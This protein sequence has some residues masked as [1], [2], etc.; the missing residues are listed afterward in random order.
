MEI[1]TTHLHADFDGL[2]SMVAARK[3]YPDAVMAFPGSQ[4]KNVRDFLGQ[5]MMVYNFQR[6]KNIQLNKVSR[7]IVVDTRQKSR[8]GRFADC[9]SN[10]GID[11]HLFDH[12][13]DAPG[14]IN[15]DYEVIKPTGSTTAIFTQLFIMK[16]TRIY[17]ISARVM[18]NRL[19]GSAL[20]SY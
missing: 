6:V 1:I 11:I 10:P 7:L 13:P 2:A 19:S 8:I 12:H 14:D 5:S 15:G 9:L 4:E 18:E 3:L 20:S 16:S 17:L